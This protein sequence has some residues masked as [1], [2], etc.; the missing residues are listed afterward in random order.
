MAERYFTPQEIGEA[1]ARKVLD[2][3][4]RAGSAREIAETI[5][6]PGELDVGVGVGQ[7]I[8][9]RR[10]A[11][12][13][14]FETLAQVYDVPLVGP[15]R[16]TEIVRVLTGRVART[17]PT[18]LA[19]ANALRAEIRELRAAVSALQAAGRAGWRVVLRPV[20]DAGYLGQPLDL[21]IEVFDGVSG[22]PKANADLT[23]AT[24]WGNLQT[25]VG[26]G[27]VAGP[28][29]PL[30]T[31]GTGKCRATLR[32]PFAEQLSRA[33][34]AALE[35]ALARLD[36]AAAAP[37]DILTSLRNMATAYGRERNSDLRG[38][39]DV[40]YRIW[41]SRTADLAVPRA[42]LN[43]WHF[44]TALITALVHPPGDPSAVAAAAA[45]RV[46]LKDWVGPW[47]QAYEAVL[48]D[49]DRLGAA[50]R[51]AGGE[52]TDKDVLLDRML[53]R[54]HGYVADQRGRAG[55]V[56]AQKVAERAIRH[57]MATDLQTLP[58]NIRLT[59]LPTLDIAHRTV[60]AGGMGTLATVTRVHT[61]LKK[62][63]DDRIGQL[64]VTGDLADR[65]TG[66]EDRL[67]AAEIDSTQ[68]QQ[69]YA[70][71]NATYETFTGQ[72][73]DFSGRYTTFSTQY[74]DFNQRYT[75]FAADYNAF[76]REYTDFSQK[77]SQF[78]QE[79]AA[80]ETTTQAAHQE[81]EHFRTR[82]DQFASDFQ[83]FA[84]QYNQFRQDYSV[85]AADIQRFEN[86]FQRFSNDFATF[87]VDY[88]RFRTDIVR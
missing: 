28:V 11:L 64:T 88:N 36:P 81:M 9:D 46:R 84:T 17:G 22:R 35:T 15:E 6:I 71:F 66:I 18:G 77:Y 82:Y 85:V 59:L 20:Q 27:M 68:F 73:A 58:L 80:I 76:A 56:I 30:R 78:T 24:T 55:E 21:L 5:E 53:A 19:E 3:L 62:R 23:L 61:D 79:A 39:V 51:N 26:F 52:E 4:N 47:L 67:A 41:R 60:R 72:Y 42:Q 13:G 29:L 10:A 54:T 86:D 25:F 87:K 43:H 69:D 49:E 14:A 48:R 65:L 1:D 37:I 83:T 7:R 63:V 33:Q 16:F 2:F 45:R 32:S 44:H 50:L 57:Y 74:A 40:H 8:L 34:Q 12:G 38:A 75:E 31:D 70:Q